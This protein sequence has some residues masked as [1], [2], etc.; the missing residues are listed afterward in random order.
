MSRTSVPSAHAPPLAVRRSLF[1]GRAG[2]HRTCGIGF[3]F[4]IF[5]IRSDEHHFEMFFRM[6]DSKFV[7]GVRTR[8][9]G[10]VKFEKR[11]ASVKGDCNNLLSFVSSRRRT[12][13]QGIIFGMFCRMLDSNLMVDCGETVPP[14]QGNLLLGYYEHLMQPNFIIERCP[15]MFFSQFLV[16]VRVGNLHRFPNFKGS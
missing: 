1:N 3:L 15:M 9:Y 14:I 16:G 7:V 8:F 10:T 2:L 4:F 11:R 5:F 12:L 6:L 13:P